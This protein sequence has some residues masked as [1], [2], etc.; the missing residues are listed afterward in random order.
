MATESRGPD[1]PQIGHPPISIEISPNISTLAPPE[2]P[3]AR[4]LPPD[5]ELIRPRL[6]ADPRFVDR[7]VRQML[8]SSLD[9]TQR[10]FVN[11]KIL[12]HWLLSA[13]RS[14]RFAQQTKKVAQQ[15]ELEK[16]RVAKLREEMA[17]SEQEIAKL[18]EE[19]AR[20]RQICGRIV[21]NSE[22]HVVRKHHTEG[23][24][25]HRVPAELRSW[26]AAVTGVV[27]MGRMEGGGGT[28]EEGASRADACSAPSAEY[29][30]AAAGD[31]RVRSAQVFPLPNE[32]EG[33][34]SLSKESAVG[35]GSFIRSVAFDG[36]QSPAR[37]EQDPRA[38]SN[39]DTT[40]AREDE[41]DLRTN[42][43]DSPEGPL[44]P[45]T[46]QRKAVLPQQRRTNPHTSLQHA[47]AVL[48]RA[49]LALLTDQTHLSKTS[50]LNLSRDLAT[51]VQSLC[52]HFQD[53]GRKFGAKA[54]EVAEG[55]HTMELLRQRCAA[56]ENAVE[57]HKTWLREHYN[58][59]LKHRCSRGA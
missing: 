28:R 41:E 31:G 13:A 7:R 57:E 37:E 1:D 45:T 54:K 2:P 26:R 32:G 10:D 12:R 22:G 30:S 21:L 43:A 17:R 48:Q 42:N 47:R 52:G 46:A 29:P 50:L 3:P 6:P 4:Q 39:R 18:R 9:K 16:G 38:S 20:G 55:K 59:Q 36:E 44:S 56:L 35:Q 51:S 33:T 11:G 5:S 49:G 23:A 15:L 8:W 58:E 25:G 14:S 53:L 40:I 34:F 19:V 27:A 24:A